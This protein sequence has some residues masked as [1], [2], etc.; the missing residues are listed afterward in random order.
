[1]L[2]PVAGIEP[3]AF[4]LTARPTHQVRLTGIDLVDRQG[5]APCSARL[6]GVRASLCAARIGAIPLN[7][8][9]SFAFSVQRAH[10][11]HQD[12][13]LERTA[14]IEPASLRWQRSARPLSYVR[15]VP[16]GWI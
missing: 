6:Q 13:E 11:L 7:R 14:R 1:M 16:E 4:W 5:N 12:G 8:K 15:M 2:A 10:Q 3:A 9:A